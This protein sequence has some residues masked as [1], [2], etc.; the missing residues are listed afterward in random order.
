MR[1]P[2]LMLLFFASIASAADLKPGQEEAKARFDDQAT[3]LVA[4]V[5]SACGT[6]YAKIDSNFEHFDKTKFTA[7]PGT[8]C[9]F[10]TYGLTETCKTPA[11]KKALLSKI[12]G[13]ACV[14]SPGPGGKPL[15]LKQGTLTYY[16]D[17]GKPLKGEV[18]AIKEILDK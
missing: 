18:Q 8:A 4:D 6:K 11:Y 2:I 5:N 14:F 1:T 17:Q 15:D 3:G 13:I 16:M 7:V 9:S 12:Q 10:L